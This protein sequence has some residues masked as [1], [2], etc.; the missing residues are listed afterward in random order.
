[1][2]IS[3]DAESR[4]A[5]EFYK[6]YPEAAAYMEDILV[7]IETTYPILHI[8]T[9][10]SKELVDLLVKGYKAVQLEIATANYE[11]AM[12]VVAKRA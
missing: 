2:T 1:M 7:W 9:T 11:R 4:A 10:T 3:L 6:L 12:G 5:Y 8:M